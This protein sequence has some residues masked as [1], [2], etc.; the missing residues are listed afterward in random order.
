MVPSSDVLEAAWK[1]VTG[2]LIGALLGGLG[3]G[4][5]VRAVWQWL[6]RRTRDLRTSDGTPLTVLKELGGASGE[7]S[8]HLEPAGGKSG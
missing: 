7:K 6:T 5:L 4:L 3:V 1:I 8:R 2:L